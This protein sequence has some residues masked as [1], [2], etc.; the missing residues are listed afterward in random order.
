MSRAEIERGLYGPKRLGAPE[1][2]VLIVVLDYLNLLPQCRAWRQNIGEFFFDDADGRR[3]R[4]RCGEPGMA[5][6]SG[7]L[8]GVRLEVEVKAPGKAP[9]KLQTAWLASMQEL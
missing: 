5:D 8:R 6:V 4:I 2:A 9:T 1:K 7:I 3:R